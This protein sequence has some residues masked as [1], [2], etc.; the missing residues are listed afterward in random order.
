MGGFE[1]NDL[2]G[3]FTDFKVCLCVF[4][5]PC[6]VQGKIA[7]T[8]GKSCLLHTLCF[9]VPI[10]NIVDATCIRSEA[11]GENVI[12]SFLVISMCYHLA[13][14]QEAR[15]KGADLMAG[16]QTAVAMDRA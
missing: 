5:V 15:V 2:L 10:L 9:F 8:L 11:I 7:E 12:L 3:C 6:Y 16:D 4:L 13:I 14:C 1:K